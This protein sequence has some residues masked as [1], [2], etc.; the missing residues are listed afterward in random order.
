MAGSEP[1]SMKVSDMYQ[2]P[3]RGTLLRLKFVTGQPQAADIA[4]GKTLAVRSP[5]GRERTVRIVA[6]SVTGGN[7]SQGRLDR[8][9]ELDVIVMPTGEASAGDPVGFGWTVRPGSR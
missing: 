3:L 9:R 2:V 4:V 8:V 1:F 6:H 5:D 7:V